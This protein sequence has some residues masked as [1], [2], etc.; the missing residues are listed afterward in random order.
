MTADDRSLILAKVAAD[1]A[2]DKIAKDVVAID[3]SGQLPLTDVFVLAS[4]GNERQIGAIVDAV[5][6]ALRRY[7]SKPKRR[8][9][10]REGRW[11]LLDFGDIV[12]H[13]QHEDER[14][15]YGLDRLWRDCPLID[16]SGVE[17]PPAASDSGP[18]AEAGGAEAAGAEDSGSDAP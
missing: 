10:Q 18:D 15:F 16:L 13:V 1:A 12:V 7:G 11:V 4:A 9:G 17:V 14:D 5:E 8:E 3:V 2:L 6:D